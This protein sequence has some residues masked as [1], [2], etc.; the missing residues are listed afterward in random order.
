MSIKPKVKFSI[1][2][3]IALALAFSVSTSV[4]N[5][6]F[7]S[8]ESDESSTANHFGKA[9]SECASSK[10]CPTDDEDGK[11]SMGEH[12]SSFSG[13]KRSGIGNVG[14]DIIGCNEKVKPGQLADILA[15]TG[16]CP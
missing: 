5:N 2:A 12:S 13:E 8:T 14:E 11:G 15:G 7:A 9:A 6:A 1:V 10:T 3:V 4:M 16:G